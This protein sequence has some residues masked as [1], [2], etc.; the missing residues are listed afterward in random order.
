MLCLPVLCLLLQLLLSVLVAVVGVAV[1][2]NL[3]TRAHCPGGTITGPKVIL[4][5]MQILA[6]ILPQILDL[7]CI[8]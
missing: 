2:A 3:L 4:I 8:T 6:Q 5:L 1:M 7:E